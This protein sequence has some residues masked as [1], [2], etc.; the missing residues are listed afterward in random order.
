MCMPMS[1]TC[2]C[3]ST[4]KRV[5]RHAEPKGKAGMPEECKRR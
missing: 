1:P 5:M 2:P 3:I 4:G